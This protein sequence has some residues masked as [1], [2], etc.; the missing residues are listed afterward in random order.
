MSRFGY[1]G[2]FVCMLSHMVF[3]QAVSSELAFYS[4]RRLAMGGAGVAMTN[5][6]TAL[7]TNPAGLVKSRPSVSLPSL[8]L[9][10]SQTVFDKNG[11]VQDAMNGGSQSEKL[12]RLGALV[13]IDI[14]FKFGSTAFGLTAP[15]FGFGVFSA[16]TLRI[17]LQN[18]T[19]PSLE[20]SGFGDVSPM[21]GMAKTFSLWNSPVSFGISGRYIYRA[22]IL[23]PRTKSP[24]LRKDASDLMS[25]GQ[26]LVSNIT[27][28][29][30]TGFGADVG[31]LMPLG[32]GQL[33][34][35]VSNIGTP[36]TGKVTS[37]NITSDYSENVPIVTTIGY[38]QS[39]DGS[40]VPWLG[41]VIG[42]FAVAADYKCLKNDFYQNV[43]IGVEKALIGDMLTARLGLNQGYPTLGFGLDLG[44]FHAQYAYSTQENGEF[45]GADPVSHHLLQM[46]ICF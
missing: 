31:M 35:V 16:S 7:Y 32:E 28:V 41:S 10:A 37:G 23:D 30:V 8:D 27:A 12:S 43:Y 44:I 17:K 13:P 3:A 46:N 33:G 26:S 45:I 14:G 5:D 22:R 4:V 15:E 19:T 20:F 1:V 11:Q 42:R 29:P 25:G 24:I 36:L 9:G 39:V 38:A 40:E 2:L 21:I 6:I 34:I 18:P